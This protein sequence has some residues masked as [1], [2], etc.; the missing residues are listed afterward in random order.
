MKLHCRVIIPIRN[1]SVIRVGMGPLK[2]ITRYVCFR[3][4]RSIPNFSESNCTHTI[5]YVQY[6]VYE[7]TIVLTGKTLQHAMHPSTIWW[8]LTHRIRVPKLYVSI[9]VLDEKTFAINFVC[10]VFGW[11]T[12]FILHRAIVKTLWDIYYTTPPPPKKDT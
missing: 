11:C 9:S 2:K 3:S 10:V 6:Y 12:Q 7:L 8:W 5:Y 4:H 1:Q